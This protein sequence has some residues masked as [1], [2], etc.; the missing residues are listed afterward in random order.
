MERGGS[1]RGAPSFEGDGKVRDFGNWERKGPLSPGA[2]Q[3]SMR[4]GRVRS[5]EG[6]KERKLS[7]SWGE[8]RSQNGSRPPRRDFS[9]RP[10][11]ERQPTAADMDDQWRARMKPDAPTPSRT[12]EA[13]TPNSPAAPVAPAGRPR[14][15]LQKR[16][17]SEVEPALP[18]A[19]S[20]SDAKASPFGAARPIDTAAREREIE[21]KRQ[22]ALRQKKEADEK[23]R[24]E[25]KARETAER[26]EK[27]RKSSSAGTDVEKEK[28]S[29]KSENGAASPPP[30]KNFEILRRVG[31]GDGDADADS[32]DEPVNGAAAGDKAVKPK[33]VVV[34]PKKEQGSWRRKGSTPAAAPEGSTTAALEEDGW[35]TVQKNPKQ[36][37]NRRGGGAHPSRALAS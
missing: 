15:N 32:T 35:S 10:P 19:S 9:D 29:E 16:T 27:E 25:K 11:V 1:R 34:D 26:A 21:E 23:A 28:S 37:G 5:N 2:G 33:E 20:T 31:E 4:E 6:A 24:E 7:P 18:S 36:R 14:L 30:G 13:S 22:L 12:P 17:V 8:G 3:G